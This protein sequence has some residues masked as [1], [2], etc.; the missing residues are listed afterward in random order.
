[1]F[2]NRNVNSLPKHQPYNYTIDLVEGTQPPFGLV[3]NLSQDKLA[4]FREYFNENLEKGFIQHL[5]HSTFKV[6]SQCLILFVKKKNGYLQMCVDYHGL[7]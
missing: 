4:M 5:V 3:Y 7:N 1:V 2:E 6:S